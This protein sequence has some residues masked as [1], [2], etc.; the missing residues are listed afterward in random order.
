MLNPVETPPEKPTIFEKPQKSLGSWVLIIGALVLG[1]VLFV[2]LQLS[3]RKPAATVTLSA[4]P[5]TQPPALAVQTLTPSM[6]PTSGPASCQQY[7]LIPAADPT[8]SALFPPITDSDWQEGSQEA[9]VT[10]L[11]YSD[12][13]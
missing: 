4:Q 12:F 6:V 3:N 2:G 11:E 9:S 8:Q 5:A 10:I 13:M 7:S 1:A